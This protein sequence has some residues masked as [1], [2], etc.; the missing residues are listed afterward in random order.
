M[1]PM[2]SV[3]HGLEK[4]DLDDRQQALVGRTHLVDVSAATLR[5]DQFANTFPV[6]VINES[7]W[8]SSAG[9]DDSVNSASDRR[10][11]VDNA[12]EVHLSQHQSDEVHVSVNST[13]NWIILCA[14]GYI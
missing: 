13:W 1:A 14:L 5:F 8:N 11:L 7:T 10:E 3:Q 4:K 12:M 2:P 6:E 9:S